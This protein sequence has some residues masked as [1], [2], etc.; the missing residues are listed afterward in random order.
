MNNFNGNLLVLT[1]LVNGEFGICSEH[2]EKADSVAHGRL[3]EHRK[4][5]ERL[6]AERNTQNEQV[7]KI[8]KDVEGPRMI[9]ATITTTDARANELRRETDALWQKNDESKPLS[10]WQNPSMLIPRILVS[11][12]PRRRH[13]HA[14][15][16]TPYK[17]VDSTILP[18]TQSLVFN[19]R[20]G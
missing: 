7:A 10:Q 16:H 3:R 18:T 15:G 11:P 19:A 20:V 12:D 6:T 9:R 5:L 8:L 14:V 13:A 1:V 2:A 17:P 4:R